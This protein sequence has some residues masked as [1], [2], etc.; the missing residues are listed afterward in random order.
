ML[1]SSPSASQL[2]LFMSNQEFQKL[3]TELMSGSGG[4][5]SEIILGYL[6]DVSEMLALISAVRE[7]NIDSTTHSSCASTPPPTVCIWQHELCQ[8]SHIPACHPD[9]TTWY[10]T[11]PEAWTELKENGFG[12]SLSGGPFSTVHG[13]YIT[14][15]TIKREVKVRGGPLQGGYST[16]LKAEDTFTSLVGDTSHLVNVVIV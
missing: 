6:N 4:T 11:N 8:V 2:D 10:E 13:N 12:V 3:S 16:S 15:V 7:N 1:R 14:E 9:K 5:Q